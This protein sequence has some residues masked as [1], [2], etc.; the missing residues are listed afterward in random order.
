MSSFE[1]NFD[2]LVGPTHNYAGLS[3]GNLASG[4]S[5]GDIANP[6]AAAKQGLAKMKALA[7]M[8]LQQAVLP[9]HERPNL[10]MLRR[11]GF[12][13]DDRAVFES[14]WKQTPEVAVACISAA[15]MW[16]ANAATVSPWPDTD[17]ERTH[18]TAANLSSMFHRSIEHPTTTRVLQSIFVDPDSYRHH[19]AL[20]AGSH[21]ADEGAA[22]H[23]RFCADYGEAGVEM[24]VFGR[25]AFGH[26][27]PN[28]KTFPARQ[29]FEASRAI[30]MAHGLPSDRVVYAQQ[31]PVAIDAGVFHNDVIA[32]GDRNVLL[33]HDQA[34]LNSAEL[35]DELSRKV[36]ATCGSELIP[37]QVPTSA[38]SLADAV[39][40][41][42]FNSQL[43]RSPG[44]G[45]VLV[46][47]QQCRT[48]ARVRSYLDQLLAD[49][50]P[51]EAVH[52]L[53]LH[54]SMKNGGG[55]ACLRLRVVMSD[56]QIN[57]T[58]AK[59]FVTDDQLTA[60][61]DWVDRHYRDRLS[62]N[63]LRDPNLIDESRAALDELTQLLKIGS[64]YD[65]Q[66]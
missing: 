56:K 50:N 29:T 19:P 17:D 1:V 51:I 34:F 43:L 24:Y 62:G 44:G 54:Q 15:P 65:F 26:N 31:N 40:T 59:V 18:F 27:R 13:G 46:A 61:H 11:L 39:S 25:Y 63:D 8:G 37:I 41:Y 53:D 64:V 2:G 5:A 6:Q 60:L 16:V 49:N 32:V 48:N 38:V 21:F 45:T 12:R 10:A 9:P 20:P 58:Q 3:R 23:T 30:A 7:D 57:A 52:Y 33:Y 35:I 55:P 28:A 22:N 47:P 14:A 42:L 36:K 4:D 66:R